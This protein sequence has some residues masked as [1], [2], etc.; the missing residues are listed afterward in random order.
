MSHLWPYSEG[1]TLWVLCLLPTPLLFTP[2]LRAYSLFSGL[3][4]SL[5]PLA[6]LDS[7]ELDGVPWTVREVLQLLH[8]AV[9]LLSL[10]CRRRLFLQREFVLIYLVQLDL[11]V[12][13]VQSL[14]L[15]RLQDAS[16]AH[17][18][19]ALELLLLVRRVDLLELVSQVPD[20][21]LFLS[22]AHRL[23]HR[24]RLPYWLLV[25]LGWLD[26][27]VPLHQ[28]SRIF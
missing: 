5:A 27:I 9:G 6:T 8:Y 16:S 1:F 21:V 20:H 12:G 13:L 17:R 2:S 28:G 19:V 3:L 10:V 22:L 26:Q 4:P 25:V 14:G 7:L 11:G 23:L 18:L 24:F 15:L